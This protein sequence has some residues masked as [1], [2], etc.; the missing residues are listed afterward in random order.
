MTYSIQARN[1]AK[2]FL[3]SHRGRTPYLALRDVIM[4]KIKGL[5]RGVTSMFSPTNSVPS[6]HEE[7]WAL[8]DVSFE[9][10]VGQ[11]VGI[12]GRNGAG[13][14][15]LLKVL[16]RITE[17]TSGSARIRGRLASLLEV[18]TGFHPE[19]SGRENI[20]LN[21]AI[22][23]MSRAEISRKFDEI[24]DFSGVEKFLDTS[25]KHYSSGMRVRLAFSVA[26]HLEPDILIVDEVLSVG[27]MDFQQKCMGKMESSARDGRTVLVVSHDLSAV[28]R[29]CSRAILLDKGSV[30]LDGNVDAVIS[31][32]VSRK[33]DEGSV[34]YQ[35]AAPNKAVN[36]RKAYWRNSA[37][38]AT[39][40]VRYDEDFELVIEYEVNAPVRNC[41]IWFGLR[42]LGDILAFGSADS[43]SD[44]A[45]LDERKPGY[46]RT[47]VKMPSKWLNA[48]NYYTVLGITQYSPTSNFDRVEGLSLNVLELGTPERLR[49]GNARPG[50]LQPYLPWTTETASSD[51][52]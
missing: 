47:S 43:D 27:D 16:S 13:K 21:G 51:R 10:P 32:Y 24:V 8:R 31:A 2:R 45:Q 28:H 34:Y 11:S 15:T 48:G 6:G 36:L 30:V 52:S 5:G 19:L 20:F 33:L 17:P 1:L 23:G 37:G 50:I 26:A 3:I 7:F 29:L 18:G 9:V 42:T 39:S 14:S 46:Y 12:I 35:T 40:E 4:D 38:F 25:V 41:C 44:A 22:L 49:T